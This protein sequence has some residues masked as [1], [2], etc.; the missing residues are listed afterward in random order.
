MY[1]HAT[2]NPATARAR[3]SGESRSGQAGPRLRAERI[4]GDRRD[5]RRRAFFYPSVPDGGAE[6]LHRILNL[7][8]AVLAL[9]ILLPLILVVALAVKLSSPG[10]VFYRQIR[11]GLDR[12]GPVEA[13]LDGRRTVD[14]GGRPFVI[15]KFRTMRADAEVSSGPTWATPDDDRVT[16]V[17]RFLRRYR[18][19][20]IPQ[21]WNVL[22]GDMSVVGPRPERP[23]FVG[24]LRKEIANYPLRHKV[25]P[26]ITGW[27]QVNRGYDQGVSDVREKLQYD[28]EYLERRSVWFD[29]KVM[30]KTVP[31]MLG[32]EEE[33]QGL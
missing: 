5:R 29:L 21:F 11:I 1:L 12:R 14:L 15:Y 22:K 20:E 4:D 23:S 27:A 2:R 19:D 26:G 6:R 33:R 31:V 3:P 18:L 32:R 24:Y 13:D 17:G 10:P 28:L 25:P 30:W 9:V 16:R 7:T 8:I